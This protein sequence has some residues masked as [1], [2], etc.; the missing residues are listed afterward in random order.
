MAI[1]SHLRRCGWREWAG[2]GRKAKALSGTRRLLDDRSGVAKTLK[3]S[4]LGPYKPVSAL[5]G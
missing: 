1:G 5:K 4:S 3:L 2:I